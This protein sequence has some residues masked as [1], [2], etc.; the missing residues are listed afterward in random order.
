MVFSSSVFL[1]QFLP[2]TLIVYYLLPKRARNFF[3][4]IDSL[5]FFAWNQLNY[6][7]LILFSIV[8]NYLGGLFIDRCR[9]QSFRRFWLVIAILINLGLLGYFKYFNFLMENFSA[10]TGRAI[11]FTAVILPIGIS[12]FTFQSMSYVIDVYRKKAAVQKNL[13]N[14]ALYVAMFPQL[15]AGPIVRY[16]DVAAEIDSRS[17]NLN[18][19]YDGTV[20][21]ICGLAKKVLISNTLAV[22]VD[23]IWANGLDR[24]GFW[25]VWAGSILYTLQIYFDFSGYSDMAIGLGRYFGFHFPENFNLPYISRS[26]TEFWRRWHISLSG[27]FRDYVYIPLGGNRKHVLFN[28]AVVFLLTGIWHG[29]QWTFVLWGIYN[30]FFIIIERI[31]KG[32]TFIKGFPDWSKRLF[33]SLYTLFIVNLGW[34][35][36]RAPDLNQAWTWIRQMFGI[37]LPANPGFTVFW[38]LNHLVL[39][40]AIAGIFFSSSWPRRIKDRLQKHL[41]QPVFL[42]LQNLCCILLFLASAMSVV[43]GA[44]NPFI[45]FQF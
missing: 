38:Y 14:L 33:G 26:I 44:Y 45:Y 43:S 5:I 36:F 40:A 23:Q 27:W 37:G 19:F 29:A 34:V 4:L 12:F 1:F 15:I 18:D 24:T 25:I 41:S 35:L 39:A 42:I 13:F 17:V 16:T 30:G 2:L 11:D 22:A 21:F 32:K 28:L 3:L 31:L 20:R 6:L 7:W 9:K 8:V 10:L